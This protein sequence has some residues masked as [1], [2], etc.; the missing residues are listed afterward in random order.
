MDAILLLLTRL[1]MFVYTDVSEKYT[2][3]IVRYYSRIIYDRRCNN[4][5]F[6]EASFP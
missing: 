6:N 1:N 5:K 4:L 2:A 3:S